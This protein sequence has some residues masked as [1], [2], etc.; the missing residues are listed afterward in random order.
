LIRDGRWLKANS[1]AIRGLIKNSAMLVGWKTTHAQTRDVEW[2]K[3]RDRTF[4]ARNKARL[5]FDN[6][7][8]FTFKTAQRMLL[9]RSFE[10]GDILVVF[11]ETP[12]GGARCAFYE[13]HQLSNP[14]GADASI[15]KEGVKIN[16]AGAHLAYG[17][18]SGDSVKVIDAQDAFLFGNFDSVGHVRPH[19]PLG[20]AINHAKDISETRGFLKLAIKNS[21]LFGVISEQ[22]AGSNPNRIVGGMEASVTMPGRASTRDDGTGTDRKIKTSEVFDGGVIPETRPGEKLSIVHD[23]RPHPNQLSFEENLVDEIATGW[24]LAK[25]VVMILVKRLTGPGVRFVMSM[26]SQWIEDKQEQLDEFCHRYWVY[27]TA[28][29]I[30]SGRL[31]ECTDDDWMQKLKLTKRRSLTIDRGKEGKQRLDE[32]DSGTATLADWSEETTGDDWRDL[33]DQVVAEHKYKVEA[34]RVAGYKYT[35]VFRPRQGAA[36]PEVEESEPPEPNQDPSE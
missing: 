19:P 2:N 1:G 23:A 29:E 7:G 15:W 22:A 9:E 16:K 12:S 33:V 36:S 14:D 20:Y 6:A 28:K 31:R 13:A 25:E 18:K 11:T 5:I 35:E 17:V 34:S 30:K 10:D 24:G 4:K 3:E 21:S 8:K 27:D 26:A 32:I